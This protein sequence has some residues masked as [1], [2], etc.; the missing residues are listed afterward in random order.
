MNG[1]SFQNDSVAPIQMEQS[2]V[3]KRW[4]NMLMMRLL[5]QTL[6][7]LKLLEKPLN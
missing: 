5:T 4:A 1:K 6:L 2:L 3:S 7:L